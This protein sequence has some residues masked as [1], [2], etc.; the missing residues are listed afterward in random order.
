MFGLTNVLVMFGGSKDVAFNR[1]VSDLVGTTRVSRTNWNLGA[2]AGRGT[3]HGEDMIILRPE[4][5]RQLPEKHA[6][7]IAE[8][9]KPI[10]AG[11]SRCI[12]GK[13]G[14]ALLQ[15][16]RT[17]RAQLQTQ[18]RNQISAEARQ[19]AESVTQGTQ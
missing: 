12:E 15:D 18:R 9:C 5:V 4:D 19:L 10:I 16:Q 7:V 1:E 14:A 2:A 6:L 11:L 3:A 13:A 8:N 17:L